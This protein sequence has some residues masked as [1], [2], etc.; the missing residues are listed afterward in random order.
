MSFLT[1]LLGEGGLSVID[2]ELISVGCSMHHKLLILV[3]VCLG[4]QVCNNMCMLRQK[5]FVVDFLPFESLAKLDVTRLR[6]LLSDSGKTE[7]L[8]MEVSNEI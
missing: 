4:N 5:S 2:V 3:V 1:N 7:V 8:K 6:L